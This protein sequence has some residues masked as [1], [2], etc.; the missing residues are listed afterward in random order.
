MAMGRPVPLAAAAAVRTAPT[1]CGTSSW[2]AGFAARGRAAAHTRRA[3]RSLATWAARVRVEARPRAPYA[4]RACLRS[5]A[6]CLR[7][8]PL[9][10]STRPCCVLGVPVQLCRRP[11]T[12]GPDRARRHRVRPASR[13][14]PCCHARAS[15]C[16][17]T[18]CLLP[19]LFHPRARPPRCCCACL[20]CARSCYACARCLCALRVLA[21]CVLGRCVCAGSSRP[22]ACRRV[23]TPRRRRQHHPA[24]R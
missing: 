4:P 11:A 24:L 12:V 21:R 16:L 14:S 10:T 18:R 13:A 19:P 22:T 7:L 23:S 5:V 3:S 6:L 1:R 9:R 8:S 15:A 17:P 20:R 2:R